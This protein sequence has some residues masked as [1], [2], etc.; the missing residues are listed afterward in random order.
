MPQ[1]LAA[2]YLHIIFSTKNRVPY[3]RDTAL[4]NSIHAYMGSISKQL[5]CQPIL[6]GGIAD[7]V[8]I[9]TTL[10][11][12]TATADL[13]KELKRISTNWLKQPEQL[14]SNPHLADFQWQS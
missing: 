13:V 1:S 2:I 8:H 10:S 4:R 3:L 5:D 6:T 11:R 14:A 12:T 7:H 9:L